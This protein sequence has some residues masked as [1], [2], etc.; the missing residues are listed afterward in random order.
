MNID[1]LREH[2]LEYNIFVNRDYPMQSSHCFECKPM[3]IFF[4]ESDQDVLVSFNIIIPPKL[5]AF[6]I[7]GFLEKLPDAN[8]LT[9]ISSH[10][11]TD[12]GY[13]LIENE[14]TMVENREK[15]MIADNILLNTKGFEC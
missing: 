15:S 4:N 7:L 10:Y 3:I 9:V 12:T 8:N 2:L 14:E 5:V 1:E 13:A 11:K 6:Y